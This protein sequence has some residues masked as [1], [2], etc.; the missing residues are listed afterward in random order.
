MIPEYPYN[1]MEL[2][3]WCKKITAVKIKVPV[4]LPEHGIAGDE[5]LTEVEFS[6]AHSYQFTFQK[7]H[8]GKTPAGGRHELVLYGSTIS[9]Y[10]WNKTQFFPGQLLCFA[11]NEDE[12]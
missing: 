12:K 8:T 1:I 6:L 10:W 3:T 5:H 7:G 2:P 11:K 9:K 4:D